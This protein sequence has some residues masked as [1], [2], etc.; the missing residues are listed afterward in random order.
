MLVEL[1]P[2]ER[3]AQDAAMPAIFDD[4][5]HPDR[6]DWYTRLTLESEIVRGGVRVIPE[7][8]AAMVSESGLRNRRFGDSD[9]SSPHFGVGWMQYDTEYYA[10]PLEELIAIRADPLYSLQYLTQHPDLFRQGGRQSWFNK[11]RWHAWER[12]IIDPNDGWSPLQAALDAWER[13]TA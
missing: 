12:D 2:A 5:F 4:G 7:F 3:A 8:I 11:Q 13:V 9:V 10:A 1:T 6:I